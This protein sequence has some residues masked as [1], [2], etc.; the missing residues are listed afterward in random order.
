VTAAGTTAVEAELSGLAPG[1]AYHLRLAAENAGGTG[2]LET[3]NSFTTLAVP[4]P[5]V[6]IHPVTAFS[7]STAHF[8]GEINPNAPVGSPAVSDISWHFKCTPQCR[9]VPGG[10]I[11]ADSSGHAIAVDARSLEPNTAYQVT[12]VA[13]NVEGPTDAGP[14]GFHTLQAPPQAETLPVGSSGADSAT[15]VANVNPAN[16]PVTYQFNWGDSDSYGDLAPASPQPLPLG[17]IDNHPHSVTARVSG[18]QH[19]KTYHYRV[20]ATN[21]DTSEI[22]EGEDRTFVAL[23]PAGPPSPCS[24]SA[25]RAQ[26]KASFLAD[27]RAYEMVSPLDKNAS[28]VFFSTNS[29]LAA[30][31]GEAAIFASNSAFADPVTGAGTPHYLSR[32]TPNGWQTEQML[33]SF[34]RNSAEQGTFL[35]GATSNLETALIRASE[36]PLLAGVAPE[37]VNLFERD[38]GTRSYS[39]WTPDGP[40]GSAASGERYSLNFASASGDFSHIVYESNQPLT[41]DAPTITEPPD[42]AY[43]SNVFESVHGQTRLVSIL[44]DGTPAPRGGYAGPGPYDLQ[45]G[46]A[47]KNA[48]NYLGHSVSEDGARIFWTDAETRQLYVR[49]GGATT[50]HISASQRVPTDPAGSRP[51]VW[52]DA[53]PDGSMVLFTS[54]EKLTDDS[55]ASTSESGPVPDLYRYDLTTSQLVDVSVDRYMGDGP[56][57]A[58]VLGVLGMSQDGGRVYFAATGALTEAAASAGAAANFAPAFIYLWDRGALTYVGILNLDYPVERRNY[59]LSIRGAGGNRNARVTPDGETLLFT[60]EVPQT[61]AATDGHREAYLFGASKGQSACISCPP[62]GSK[63]EFDA[64]VE[65]SQNIGLAMRP[66]FSRILS[67]DGSRAFFET[68]QP[69]VGRDRNGRVDVYMWQDGEVSLI[70]SGTGGSDAHFFEASAD[71]GS[72]FFTSRERLVAR[73]TDN[74]NDVYVARIGGGFLEPPSPPPACSGEACQGAGSSAPTASLPATAAVAGAGNRK[75]SRNGRTRSSCPKNHHKG[76]RSGKRQCVKKHGA[77][78]RSKNRA[79]HKTSTGRN[80]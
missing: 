54:G 76:K 68:A 23:E 4:A 47:F 61:A 2:A 46:G 74:N 42:P 71:G 8:S 49:E 17:V 33:P 14:Q 60:S 11:P 9:N 69:L 80:G 31:N 16:S 29:G 34:N 64:T 51:V 18:L 24:N 13:E 1:T 57:Q 52:R 72:V 40:T 65:A 63:P 10:E 70:S 3:A 55:D 75:P 48:E 77:E 62:A 66:T 67:P 30:E 7:G 20:V 6:A 32:R 27:C 15:L 56:Q 26:Q 19:G 73:D 38:N 12:L 22:V 58:E 59:M 44:P 39:R 41:S 28:D 21:T 37:S 79:A 25:I 50:R 43:T 35:L 5:S 45:Q 53:T 36:P 78:R